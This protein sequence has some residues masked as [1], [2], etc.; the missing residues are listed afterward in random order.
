M[1]KFFRPKSVVV[2][3]VSESPRNLSKNIVA[4][5]LEFGFKGIIYQVGREEGTLFSRK[6]YNS[7]MEIEDPIELAVILTPAP[8]IPAIVEDCGKKGIRHVIIE[9]AGFREYG[10]SGR[11][12]EDE[13]VRVAKKHGIRFIGP[14]CIGT[15]DIYSG[16]MTS[17]LGMKDTFKRG[18]ISVITN[19]GGVGFSYLTIFK[20]EGLGLSKFASIGNRINVNENDMLEYYLKD[21]ETDIIAMYLEGIS[22]GKRLM[23]LARSSKKPI[24]IHKANIGTHARSI[25]ATHTASLSSDDSVVS[26]AF[27]QCGIIRVRDKESILNSLKILPMPPLKGNNLAIISRSGGYAIVAADIS[28]NVGFELAPLSEALKKN[29]EK[30]MRG[31]VI[32]ITNPIDVGDLFD[33]GMYIKIIEKMLQQKNVDGVVFMHIYLSAEEGEMTRSLL[34]NISELTKKYNKP[35]GVCVAT[36]EDEFQRLRKDVS[37]PIFPVPSATMYAMARSRDFWRRQCE[38]R[39][40]VSEKSASVPKGAKA[41]VAKVIKLCKKQKRN[42]L[43]HEAMDI[44][45]A[46]G[47]SVVDGV[48]ARSADEA[49]RAAKKFR[50]PVVMKIVSN[51]ISHKTDFGGVHLNIRGDEHVV[52]AYKEMMKGASRAL[53]SLRKHGPRAGE[54]GPRFRGDG[55]EGVL[56]QPMLKDGCELILGTK[57]DPNFGPTVLAGLG[58]IFVEILKDSRV[59]VCPFDHVEAGEMLAELKGYSILKGARGGKPYDT[60]VVEKSLLRL[61]RLATDFPEIKEIDMNPFYLLHKGKGGVALDARVIL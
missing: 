10:E 2:V 52:D 38:K 11:K 28:E 30:K 15:M 54:R 14:N 36:D 5:L 41:R 6:I 25:A 7:I 56:V 55:I 22:D 16:L 49:V 46:Y 12:I 53:S 44:F 48:L 47:I 45:K 39:H 24:I 21:D 4:N 57:M 60:D 1:E 31:N 59:R 50:Y 40:S 26:A 58:G 20:N 61:S 29:I 18:K 37:F 13:I 43:I 33:Y 8:T 17:F 3:G 34:K 19:S 42:P 35:V 27:K 23:E 32:K 51:E 9:S